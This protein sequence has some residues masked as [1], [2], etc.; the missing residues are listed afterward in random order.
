M[1]L[2]SWAAGCSRG[3]GG[4]C[5]LVCVPTVGARSRRLLLSL[6]SVDLRELLVVVVGKITKIPPNKETNQNL[7]IEHI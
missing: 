3:E 2:P 1:R 4:P 5:L 7:D 6:C